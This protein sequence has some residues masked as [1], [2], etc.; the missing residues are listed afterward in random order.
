MLAA[1][2]YDVAVVGG[3]IVGL[4][5]ACGLAKSGLNVVIVDKGAGAQ[6]L[7]KD[8]LLRVSA[9]NLASQ[10]L[11]EYI[12][13]WNVMEQSRCTP[14]T[15][16]TVWDKNGA[17]KID[18]DAN[19]LNSN[20]GTIIENHVIAAAL[21][22]RAMEFSNLTYLENSCVE[23]VIF[24]ER[25]AWLTLSSHQQFSASLVI[26]AD[27]ANS[28]IRSQCQIP[29]TFWDYQH[30]A[31]VASIHTD[32]PHQHTA[33]QIFTEQGVLAF[34]PLFE[35]NLCSI[36][37]SVPPQKAQQLM[38]CDDKEFE[39]ALTATFEGRLGLCQ[40]AGDKQRQSFPLTMRYAR[41][42]AQHRLMLAG[43]AAHTIHPLAGQGMN[44]GLLDAA[45]IIE[46]VSK[47]YHQDKDI[48]LYRHLRSLERWRKADAVEMIAGMEGLKRL[49]SGQ[50]PVKKV[51]RN[52]GLNLVDKLPF[53]KT[54]LIEQ[55]MGKTSR[56]PDL[57]K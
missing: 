50:Q 20:L 46:V 17:G 15:K 13:V 57:C 36:V 21:A 45:S 28:S 12:G 22:T 47:L 51:I 34:L 54:K 38:N 35:S 3:G 10:R 25:E 40:L 8:A 42:F 26:A 31:I 29:L 33:R 53:V 6:R 1:Q 48:G 52:L 55:A 18:F 56:L 2:S 5:T 37:W 11:F 9:I 24:G 30:H 43:D 4:T 14:Y 41:Q 44:L 27:G 49:F 19:A 7:T 39:K 16:M 23:N 32:F